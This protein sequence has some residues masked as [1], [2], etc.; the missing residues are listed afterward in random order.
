MIDGDKM[1]ILNSDYD[2]KLKELILLHNIT[3]R[4]ILLGEEV[5][6]DFNS[7]LQPIKEFRDSYEHILRIFKYVLCPDGKSNK[8]EKDYI[9]NQISKALGHEYRAFFDVADW[10][11][12]ICRKMAIDAI[13]KKENNLKQI[14]KN[15]PDYEKHVQTIYNC[16]DE[17]SNL[18]EKKDIS[19]SI[20]ETVNQ[21]QTVLMNIYHAAISIRNATIIVE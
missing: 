11:S 10:F 8:N 7:Y 21:Y 20:T 2:N 12:I 6:L 19:K 13:D 15:C 17:I 5:A 3:K 16:G 1:K 18:R 14:L 4:Y 9:D